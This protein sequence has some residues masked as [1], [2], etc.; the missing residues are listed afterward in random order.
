M[1]GDNGETEDEMETLIVTPL[2]AT[3]KLRYIASTATAEN[4]SIQFP[5]VGFLHAAS[6]FCPHLIVR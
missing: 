1:K 5:Y 6:K 2:T 4:H 3:R